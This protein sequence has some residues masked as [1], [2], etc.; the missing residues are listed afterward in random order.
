MIESVAAISVIA[1]RLGRVPAF[2]EAVFPNVESLE[3]FISTRVMYTLHGVKTLAE[4]GKLKADDQANPMLKH[5]QQHSL[6]RRTPCRCC[7]CACSVELRRL[8][9]FTNWPSDWVG[10]WQH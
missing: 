7:R 5:L 8:H 9:L 4:F 1:S 6:S 10:I 3:S 2:A